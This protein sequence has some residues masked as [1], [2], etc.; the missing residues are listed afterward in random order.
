VDFVVIVKANSYFL[1]AFE[2]I[3]FICF[4]EWIQ[5]SALRGNNAKKSSEPKW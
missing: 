1:V 4:R 3:E 2:S 5:E